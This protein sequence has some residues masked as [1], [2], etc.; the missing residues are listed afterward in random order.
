MAQEGLSDAQ[1]KA[2]HDLALG[3]RELLTR[4]AREVLEGTFGLYTDGRIEPAER[5]PEVQ[6][7]PETR[8]LYER[9]ARHIEDEARAGMER[10][11][12]VA[13][14]LK[15]IAFTHLNRL[16]AFKMMDARK[17][18]R[19][20]LDKYTDSNGFLFYLADHPDD[21]ALHQRGERD[22]AYRRF[23]LWQAGQVAREINVLFDPDALP[24]LI[25]PRPMALAQ[26]VEMLNAEPLAPVW[27]ADETIGWIYQYFNEPELQAAFEKVRTAGAKFE[28]KDIPSATQLFTPHWIVRYLVQNTLG[29]L[30][31]DMHPD[32]RLLGTEL[33]DYLVALEGERPVERL[34]PVRQIKLL[35][36][37]CG[38][39]H[40]GLVAFDLFAA[41]YREELER[42]GEPGWPEQPSVSEPDEIP[43]VI[44]AHNIHGIDIDLRAVQLSALAL[45]L[46]AKSINKGITISGVNLACADVLPLDGARLGGFLREARFSQPIY[47][48]LMRA[49][50]RRL[51][52]ANQ[53]GSLLRLERDLGELVTEE[54]QRI[55]RQPLFAGVEYESEAAEDEWWDILEAQIIQGLDAFAQQQAAAGVNQRFFAGEAHKGLRLLELMLDNYDVVVTNPP[56]MTRGKMNSQLADLVAQA[57]PEAKNDLFAAFIERNLEFAGERGYVGMLTMHSW[58]FL[59]SY[60]G[61]R[62]MVRERAASLTMAHCGGG[63]FDVGNPGTLQTTAFVLRADPDTRRRENQVGTY[64]RLV[65]AARGDDKRRTFEEALLALRAQEAAT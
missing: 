32:T 8:E 54:R 6:R 63:L 10:R 53:L 28:A 22:V 55:R 40:F 57:Y 50:W 25:Y 59:S 39:M 16:A 9:I 62:K 44:L 20:T 31:V 45:Y 61:F 5:L 2:I 11:E 23:L 46:K 26:L 38:A 15:E 1:R 51:E 56:Y 13:K 34:R 12:A 43:A 41:M 35:D 42:A 7:H 30:W 60:E 36:S 27:L 58:M 52:E 64:F 33:L 17:L 29:R 47:E 48:R 37:A 24:G 18:I 3:A 49:L 14:L 19:G 21:Y 4:E 65:H